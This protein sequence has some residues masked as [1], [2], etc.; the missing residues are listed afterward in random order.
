MPFNIRIYYNISGNI[1]SA[2]LLTFVYIV[3]IFLNTAEVS[4]DTNKIFIDVDKIFVDI[5][6]V[7]INI[8]LILYFLIRFFVLFICSTVFYWLYS[9]L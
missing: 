4:R 7:F 8:F 6:K 1:G 5:N 9:A 3:N 2:Y